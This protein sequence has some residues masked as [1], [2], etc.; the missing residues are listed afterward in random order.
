MKKLTAE[1]FIEKANTIHNF[2]YDY[3]EVEYVNCFSKVKI[4]C[5]IHGLFMI[6]PSKHINPDRRL[7]RTSH[8]AGCQKCS[9][10]SVGNKLKSS[11]QSFIEKSIQLH[12]LLYDY[13]L[14]DYKTAIKKVKI[15]CKEHGI[16]EQIPN[17]HLNGNGCSICGGSAKLNATSFIAKSRI[18]YENKYNYD[19]VEYIILKLKLSVKNMDYLNKLQ[20]IIC[21]DL[22]VCNA[23][24]INHLI[25]TDQIMKSL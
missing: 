21:K 14:V 22:N 10:K 6:S 4:I 1:I 2:K 17:S 9:W 16:F 19:L 20:V 7:Q 25:K 24:L 8:Y 18:I 13:S 12:G 5:K 23:E 11:S 3:T 15:I